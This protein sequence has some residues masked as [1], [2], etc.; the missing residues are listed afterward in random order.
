[1]CIL[2]VVCATFYIASSAATD[3]TAGAKMLRPKGKLA[4]GKFQ[5]SIDAEGSVLQDKRSLIRSRAKAHSRMTSIAVDAFGSAE[6]MDTGSSEEK[7]IGTELPGEPAQSGEKGAATGAHGRHSTDNMQSTL[8]LGAHS[9]SG[10][11]HASGPEKMPAGG[12]LVLDGGSKRFPTSICI[13]DPSQTTLGDTK[14][15]AQCCAVDGTCHRFIGK[16][17]AEGCIVGMSPNIQATTYAEA[18]AL[19]AKKGL[20][21]CTSNC[22][23]RGCA[24][25][26]NPVWSRLPCPDEVTTT[27]STTTLLYKPGPK[28]GKVILENSA[29]G[30]E[31]D[32]DHGCALSGAYSLTDPG[33][34]N[35]VNTHDLGRYVQVSY[36]SGPQGYANCSWRGVDWTWNPIGAG[37]VNLNPAQLISSG[38][39]ESRKSLTCTIRPIQWAC[40]NVLC[41]CTVSITYI[42][43]ENSVWAT[44]TLR[45][46][47]KDKKWYPARAQE[48]PAVYTNGPLSRLVGYT[49]AAPCT[50]DPNV[51][52]WDAGWD[53]HIRPSWLPGKLEGLTEPVLSFVREDDFGLGVYQTRAHHWL[54]GFA[55]RKGKGGTKDTPTGYIAP[56]EM[57]T[58]AWNEVYTYDFALIIGDLASIRSKAC[59]L[60]G[61]P[62]ST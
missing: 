35:L 17:N 33:K 10:R 52:E 54:A 8:N 46:D 30:I 50:H 37:D 34:P 61:T 22:A 53:R 12:V 60:K 27:T 16:H 62:I 13:K 1:M 51:K 4:R 26:N 11:Q 38:K 25:N 5:A 56:I 47:R 49:G 43:D 31:I 20:S 39:N 29:I 2:V 28:S 9:Q 15:A 59:S 24:Y 32:I 40:N 44:A 57:K 3:A 36:Y 42:L 6:S 7:R 55:G 23:N 41:D 45:N 19:C 18:S 14:I 48:L 21:L 58:L